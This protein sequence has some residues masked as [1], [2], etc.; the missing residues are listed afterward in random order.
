MSAEHVD[1]PRA[2]AR[3]EQI[4][5]AA[6]DC[7]R[8]H[9]FHGASISQIS[10]AAGMSAGHIYHYFENKEAIIAAIVARDLEHL[11]T[12]TAEMRSAC[13]LKEAMLECVT[14]GVEDNLEPH[15]AGL[16]LEI[17]AEASRNPRVAK[18]VHDAD[19][20]CRES[21]CLTLRHMRQAT[22]HKDDDA[23]LAAMVE[24]LA[25]MFEGLMCRAIRNPE[26]DKATVMRLFQRA[27]RDLLEQPS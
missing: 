7:F 11:L 13:N 14:T 10:K 20:A 25:A 5:S 27:V 24:V 21:L 15:Y 19:V 17:V 6:A 2:E 12:L 4:L 1:Q 22:G 16:N 8:S 26:I 9:G 23:T 3:R 18:I